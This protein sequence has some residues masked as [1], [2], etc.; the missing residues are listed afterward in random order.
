M[1]NRDAVVTTELPRLAVYVVKV[2][3]QS[4]TL[5]LPLLRHDRPS[6]ILLQVRRVA[7]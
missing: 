5:L 2:C 6:H 1:C 3:W 7:S 4:A